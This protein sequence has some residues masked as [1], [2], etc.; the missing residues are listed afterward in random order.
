MNILRAIK[1]KA[2]A[3]PLQ[4][5]QVNVIYTANRLLAAHAE[6]LRPYDLSVQQYNVLRILKGVYPKKHTI[7]AIRERMLD[8]TPN[9]T[10]LI[11]KLETRNLVER[12]RCTKDR[13]VIYVAIT[14]QGITLLEQISQTF[15][16]G[17]VPDSSLSDEELIQLSNLLD[18]LRQSL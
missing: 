1:Q 18:K 15:D 17:K 12:E 4:Q 10:R 7:H 13:R 8:K 9:T 11:D 5:A 16:P 6:Q 14:D 3:H 2:F